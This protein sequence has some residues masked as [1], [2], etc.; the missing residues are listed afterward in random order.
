MSTPKLPD[1]HT[2]YLSPR[3]K[4]C[5]FVPLTG[6][7]QWLFFRYLDN[8]ELSGEGFPL[9]WINFKLM[10]VHPQQRRPIDASAR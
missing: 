10:R 3:G 4:R 7:A 8:S 5:M 1:S 9:S 2:I 6:H